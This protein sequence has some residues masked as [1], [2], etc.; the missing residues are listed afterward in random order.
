MTMKGYI[1]KTQSFD[2]YMSFDSGA[3][4]KMYSITGMDSGVDNKITQV[5][6][7]YMVGGEIID[8]SQG[9]YSQFFIKTRLNTQKFMKR[10]V[11]IVPTGLGYLSIN[12]LEDFDIRTF[13]Q[14]HPSKYR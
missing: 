1:S 13:G 7:S 10:Q 8:E 3:F 2:V 14:R 4:L 6:G 11:K 9:P 12:L 5:V